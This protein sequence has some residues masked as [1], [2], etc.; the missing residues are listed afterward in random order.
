MTPLLIP[1]RNRPTSLSNVLRFLARFYPS[2][3]VIVADGSDETYKKHNRQNIEAIKGDL[4]VDYRPYATQN[5][6]VDRMLD[7]LRSDSSELVIIGS[8]DDY[9]IMETLGKG[10]AFLH[11]NKD[12]SLAIGMLVNLQ[13]NSPTELIA[14]PFIARSIHGDAPHFRASNYAHWPFPTTYAVGRRDVVIE[15]HERVREL[16]HVMLFDWSSGVHDCLRGKIK[17]LPE[18]GFVCT[19]N[20]NHSYLRPE[21]ELVFLR[22]SD[23]ILQITARIRRDLIRYASIAEEEAKR[24]SEEIMKAFLREM[25]GRSLVTMRGFEQKPMFTN[26]IVQKQIDIFEE[27]FEMGTPAR[28]RYA[29]RLAFILSDIKANAA[30][31]DNKGEKHHYETLDE[32]TSAQVAFALSQEE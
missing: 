21:A 13:L 6:Y 3:W 31:N 20:Y 9:P 5:S 30:S 28:E 14:F 23:E 15:R 16:Y 29:D 2:T 11:Q 32:Q 24:R 8:D 10:E 7:L 19:R 26:P 27:L 1:T 17:A 22:R 18:V 4:A 12:Y 25:L